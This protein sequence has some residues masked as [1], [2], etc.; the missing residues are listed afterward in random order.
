MRPL[1][2]ITNDDG[3]QARGIQHLIG[4]AQ[5]YGDIV[6]MAPEGNA[7]GQSCSI[8]CH[9]PLRV[10]TIERSDGKSLYTCSGTPADCVKIATEYF[11]D[12]KPTLMLSGINHGSNASINVIYSATMGAVIEGCLSGLQSIGF[13][14]LNHNPEADFT[15]CTAPVRTII[16]SVL[17][18]PLPEWT[19]LNVNIPRLNAQEIKGIKVCR[20]SRAQ[21]TESMERRIDPVGR[22]YWWMTGKFVCHDMEAGTDLQALEEGYVSIVPV[23]PDYTDEKAI[24]LLD[25]QF[26]TLQH[27]ET[28]R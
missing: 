7:S 13:S 26:T 8:T 16:E 28:T 5:E 17:Q 1:I 24:A 23:H 10:H 12:R 15:G 20:A 6:V 4:V 21:W 3:L 22:P 11:C 9:V 2:L 14:L 19:A 27:E 18:H 25:T